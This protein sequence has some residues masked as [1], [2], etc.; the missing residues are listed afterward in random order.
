MFLNTN[1]EKI[2][3]EIIVNSKLSLSIGEGYN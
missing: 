1:S 2:N 3:G